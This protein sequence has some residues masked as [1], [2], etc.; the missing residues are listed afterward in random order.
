[1]I[2]HFDYTAPLGPLG[3]LADRLFLA[4]YMQYLL[5]RRNATVKRVAEERSP[6]S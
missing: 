4:R 5:A 3:R 1:M 2:D 6:S